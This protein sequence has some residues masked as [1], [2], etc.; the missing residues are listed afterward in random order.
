MM[1]ASNNETYRAWSVYRALYLHFTGSYDYHTYGGKSAKLIS[2]PAM[3]K[4]LAKYEA[5]GNFSSQ[6]MVFQ[7]LGEQFDDKEDL[8]FFYLSQFTNGFRYPSVFDSDIYDAY[9]DR[10]NNFDFYFKEDIQQIKKYLDKFEADFDDIFKIVGINHP[11]ILKMVLSKTISMETFTVLDIILGFVNDI[12]KIL[13]DP[14]W[15]D[16]SMLVKNYKPFLS[17]DVSKQK[18]IIMDVLVKG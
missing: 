8:T 18:K 14:L 12:D 2:V 5:H 6:R 9:K 17:I 3:E 13:D 16:Q 1:V 15:S 4:H 10:M 7:K 11:V